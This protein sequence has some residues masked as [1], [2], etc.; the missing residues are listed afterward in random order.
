MMR[1][2]RFFGGDQGGLTLVEV[3][4]AM[5]ILGFV[6]VGFMTALGTGFRS[7][8][9]KEEQ[10]IGH[11]LVRA[12]LEEIRS[13]DY[14]NSASPSPYTLTTPLPNGYS[15]AVVTEDFCWPEPCT[16]DGNLQKNTATVFRDGDIVVSIEDLKSRR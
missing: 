6:G 13:Q 2:A 15:I 8:G 7:Q 1:I 4:V 9:I 5:A 3:I 11:N 14:L 10:V 12:A 16:P